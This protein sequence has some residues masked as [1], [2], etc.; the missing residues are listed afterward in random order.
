MVIISLSSCFQQKMPIPGEPSLESVALRAGPRAFADLSVTHAEGDVFR[1]LFGF[2]SRL[3]MIWLFVWR[4]CLPRIWLNSII[5]VRGAWPATVC[6][7]G[8][9]VESAMAI[10][11]ALARRIIKM[12]KTSQLQSLKRV[13]INQEHSW[14]MVICTLSSPS[15]VPPS[16]RKQFTGWLNRLLTILK[17]ETMYIEWVLTCSNPFLSEDFLS[18]G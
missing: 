6:S 2:G 4:I 13:L 17:I 1:C 14:L 11:L 10:E 5:P 15:P 12:S 3:G 9:W 18:W 8:C 16:Y 7:S